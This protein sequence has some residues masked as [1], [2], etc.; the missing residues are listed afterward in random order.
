MLH[1]ELCGG[2][3]DPRNGAKVTPTIVFAPRALDT[4]RQSAGSP[5]PRAHDQSTG[6]ILIG[7]RAGDR[8]VILA[9][10]EPGPNAHDRRLGFAVDV[11]HANAA[12]AEWFERDPDSDIVG[13]WHTH[14]ADLGGL[15]PED[16]GAAYGLRDDGGR[17][18]ISVIAAARPEGTALACFYLDA[19]AV[20]PA[21]P[22]PAS[23]SVEQ[24]GAPVPAP[25]VL[26]EHPATSIG[27]A[28][29][30]SPPRTARS[31]G[32]VIG[33]VLGALLLAAVLYWA[34]VGRGSDGAATALPEAASSPVAALEPEATMPPAATATSAP[35][36]TDTTAPLPTD[37]AVPSP[38]DTAAPSPTT[39]APASPT[40]VP[41]SPTVAATPTAAGPPLP[42]SL[43]FEPMTAAARTQFLAR[44]RGAD[45][46]DCY[47]VD[48]IGPEPY[49]E[50]RIGIDDD[51][52]VLRIWDV[53]SLAF[54]EPRDA[55]RT[56]QAFDLEGNPASPPIRVEVAPGA[57]YVLRVVAD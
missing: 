17:E 47:N 19:A 1:G 31:R 23:Y 54:V 42:Y 39:P 9:A 43:R 56:L 15:T 49:A 5:A 11:D 29:A 57:Y 52:P 27:P 40:P 51:P 21:V 46:A 26:A 55:P 28:P 36:P 22:V 34:F 8:I 35:A 38:T 45:C 13:V 33:A 50:L 20:R 12:L 6:G 48:L 10:T 32:G 37:T 4:I 53:P 25:G 41:P 7:K 16:V 18:V 44:A 30:A 2:E 3:D 24:G 14:P